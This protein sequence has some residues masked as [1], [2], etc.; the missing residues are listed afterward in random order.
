[1]Y[2]ILVVAQIIVAT[3]LI[4]LAFTTPVLGYA[5]WHAY[6]ETIITDDP[7]E[8]GPAAS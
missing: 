2:T 1:M 6:R 7:Q 8:S 5:T 4:G 3:A